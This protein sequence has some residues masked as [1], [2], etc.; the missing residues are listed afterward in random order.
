M[1][2][3]STLDKIKFEGISKVIRV[4]GFEEFKTNDGIALYGIKYFA[5]VSSSTPI[6][7]RVTS[8]SNKFDS[9]YSFDLYNQRMVPVSGMIFNEKMTPDKFLEFFKD[10][11]TT[12]KIKPGKTLKESFS[13]KR[14]YLN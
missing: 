2:V 4:P 10:I 12:T 9:I 7:C 6:M 11:I 8:R 13:F 5:Y 3:Y 1:S 14:E